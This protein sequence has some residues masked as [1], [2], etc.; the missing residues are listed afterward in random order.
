LSCDKDNKREYFLIFPSSKPTTNLNVTP[1]AGPFPKI[2]LSIFLLLSYIEMRPQEKT[3]TINVD[4]CI[5]RKEERKRRMR[6]S[7][8]C[9]LSKEEGGNK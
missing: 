3:E 9:I 5:G 8:I 7:L 2:P 1:F 6:F 4:V